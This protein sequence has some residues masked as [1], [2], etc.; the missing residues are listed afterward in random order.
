MNLSDCPH[1]VGTSE[2]SEWVRNVYIPTVAP[3]RFSVDRER[4]GA[5]SIGAKLDLGL[6]VSCAMTPPAPTH[7][8]TQIRAMMVYGPGTM[9]LGDNAPIRITSLAGV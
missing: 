4:A 2:H 3:E 7:L 8:Q 9:W 6:P 5:E 1:A